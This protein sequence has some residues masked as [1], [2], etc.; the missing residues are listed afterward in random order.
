MKLVVDIWPQLIL[1]SRK[2]AIWSPPL[3]VE[4]RLIGFAVSFWVKYHSPCGYGTWKNGKRICR[5]S[6]PNLKEWA[7]LLM[8]TF[9]MKSQTLLYSLDGSQSFAP[10]WLY[11]C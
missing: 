11:V 9:W 7:P 1:P 4:S 10:I 6:A 5:I 8:A 3:L 2:E